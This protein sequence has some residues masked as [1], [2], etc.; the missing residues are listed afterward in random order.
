MCSSSGAI[1]RLLFI[2]YM[3]RVTQPEGLFGRDA[4]VLVDGVSFPVG[5]YRFPSDDASPMKTSA[6]HTYG[7]YTEEERIGVE[8]KSGIY[9]I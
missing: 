2:V 6:Q 3:L 9:V 7:K 1:L 8:L 5:V 4:E